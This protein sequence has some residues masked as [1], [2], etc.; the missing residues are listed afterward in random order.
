MLN[1]RKALIGYSVYT[2]GKP[3]AKRALRKKAKEARPGRRSA[4]IAGVVAAIGAAVGGIIF[5]R[6]RR[7]GSTESPAS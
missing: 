2:A 7:S 6:K 5:W 1:K 3:L 4:G